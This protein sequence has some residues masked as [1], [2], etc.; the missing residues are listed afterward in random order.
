VRLA[1]LGKVRIVVRFADEA[2][3]GRSV[4]LV[5]NRVDWSAAQISGLAL[6]RGPRETCSPDRKGHLGV[7]AS[8]MRS[9][10]A[11]GKPGWVVFV[12]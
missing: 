2:L 3:P 1:G 12:A 10:E 4:G 8:R 6:Q 11:L 5:T 9:S 7:T